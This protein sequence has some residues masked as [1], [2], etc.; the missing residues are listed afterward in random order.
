VGDPFHSESR[1]SGEKRGEEREEGKK[2]SAVRAKTKKGYTRT[3]FG[4]ISCPPYYCARGKQRILSGSPTTQPQPSPS[5]PPS[6]SLPFHLLFRCT[7]FLSS[8]VRG[9][10]STLRTAVVLSAGSSGAVPYSPPTRSLTG[11]HCPRGIHT[12]TTEEQ[13]LCGAVG[14]PYLVL[15]SPL[16]S[17]LCA[18]LVVDVASQLSHSRLTCGELLRTKSGALYHV[19]DDVSMEECA[20]K[21]LENN[22]GSLLVRNTNGRV[23]GIVSER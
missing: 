20:N 16:T 18:P 23:V 11:R 2:Q 14:S 22:I 4:T 9:L 13:H 12:A 3:Q 19:D 21:M 10:P 1:R 6:L 15:P 17:I 5:L 7:M 8:V